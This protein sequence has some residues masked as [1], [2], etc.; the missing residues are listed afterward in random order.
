MES[1]NQKSSTSLIRHWY[2]ILAML[3]LF[4]FVAIEEQV[5]LGAAL[6]SLKLLRLFRFV[7]L[8]RLANLF[9]AVRYLKSSGFVYL[10]IIFTVRA[11]FSSIAIYTAESDYPFYIDSTDLRSWVQII[12]PGPLLS[13]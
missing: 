7:R 11:I 8:I 3:S 13:V 4:I 2:E 5:I 12:P 1:L 10:V 6:R 9:R